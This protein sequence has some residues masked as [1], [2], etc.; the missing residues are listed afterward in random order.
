M[1]DV[2]VIA[3]SSAGNAYLVD[4]GRSRLLL[5]CGLP[6]RRL[7]A[8]TGHSLAGVAG[9]LVSHEHGDHSRAVRDLLRMGVDVWTS[10]GTADA[11]GVL[12]HHRLRVLEDRRQV[13]VGSWTVLPFRCVHDAAEPM[14]FL[15]ATGA[16]KLLFLTDTAYSPFRFAGITHLMIECNYTA[17][18]LDRAIDDGRTHGAMRRRLLHSHLSLDN[19]LAFLE[20]HDLSRLQATWLMHLSDSHGDE[21]EMKA[22]VQ[23][24]TG[25]PVHVCDR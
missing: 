16:E 6:L 9:C 1:I 5:E 15:L 19:L 17:E 25:V 13:Q 20:A 21:A 3:S 10:R 4:D 2:R 14:G 24:A 22:A 8:G 23:R 12:D 11:L 18:Q 7:Q